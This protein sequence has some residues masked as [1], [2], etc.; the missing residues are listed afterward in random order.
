VPLISV[1]VFVTGKEMLTSFSNGIDTP[2][3]RFIIV[4]SF[5]LPVVFG[6][7]NPYGSF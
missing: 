3:E 6:S 7:L 5:H 1:P 2:E 4:L